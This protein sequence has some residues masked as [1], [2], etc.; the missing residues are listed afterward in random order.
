MSGITRGLTTAEAATDPQAEDPR[1]RGRTY[2]IPFERV[3]S[4]A[5][6][7][8]DGGLAR[9]QLAG[10]DDVSGVIRARWTTFFSKRIADVRIDIGLDENGQTRVD[11][12]ARSR[13]DRGDLGGNP[14]AIG[15]FLRR[16]D[17]RLRADGVR[18]PGET[19]SS[20]RSA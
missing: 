8:A 16:L 9:W 2:A 19:R 1:L 10:A 15:H 13:G 7:I 3:W 4:A 12:R 18:A 5:V 17:E 11:L 6:S 14:R 20:A